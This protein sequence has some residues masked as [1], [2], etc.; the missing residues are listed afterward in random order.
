MLP[1]PPLFFFAP[2]QLILPPFSR[3]ASNIHMHTMFLLLKQEPLWGWPPEL[4]FL[5][6]LFRDFLLGFFCCWF[7]FW[8]G[9]FFSPPCKPLFGVWHGTPVLG[10]VRRLFKAGQALA[11]CCRTGE[12]S[13]NCRR[14]KTCTVGFVL[15]EEGEWE[16]STLVSPGFSLCPFPCPKVGAA[17][18]KVV[19]PRCLCVTAEEEQ[20]TQ[21]AGVWDLMAMGKWEKEDVGSRAASRVPGAMLICLQAAAGAGGQ[22]SLLSASPAA[23]ADGCSSPSCS[24]RGRRQL[25]LFPRSPLPPVRRELLGQGFPQAEPSRSPAPAF[26]HCIQRV[27]LWAGLGGY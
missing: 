5:V 23:G 19:F 13:K 12:R 3:L 15:S 18:L 21:P 20:L 6:W 14:K 24:S 22:R 27:V 11:Q 10:S 17:L 16:S 1:P 7:L 26:W 4:F 2:L 9:F 25:Q 8:F